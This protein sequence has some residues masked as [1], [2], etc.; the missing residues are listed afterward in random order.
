EETLETF[1]LPLL[2]GRDR[3][4]FLE[5]HLVSAFPRSSYRAAPLIS[6]NLLKPGTAVLT[7]LTTA[8][9]VTSK[10]DKLDIPVTGVWGMSMLL[11]LM[12]RRLDMRDIILVMPS[13]HYLRI[14]VIKEGVPVLTRCIH[15]YHEDNNIENDSDTNEILRTRQH[16]ENHRIFEHGAT[17]PVLYLGDASVI[18]AHLTRAGL[19]LLPVP[20]A[21][22]PDGEA[23]YLHPLFEYVISSPRGQLAPL[24][25]RARHLAENIRLTA[26]LGIAASLLSIVLFGQNDFRALIDLH[27]KDNSLRADLQLAESESQ[28]LEGHISASGLDPALVRQATRFAALEMEAAPTP[29][30]LFRFAASAIADLPQV[31]IKSLTFRFPKAGER[32]CQGHSVIDLPLTDRKID[33]P[34]SGSLPSDAANN[35]AAGV[36]ARHTELQFTILQ[37]E[38]LAPAAQI[39]LLKRIS[40]TLKAR[41]GVQ[42]MEDPAAFSLINTLKGGFGI[43][44]QKTDNLWC[45]SIPWK[46]TQRGDMP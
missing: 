12:A 19:T 31:R 9:A 21:F 26:H 1:K 6:G 42:L 44:T 4:N 45:M 43:D 41:D 40:A 24:Q 20:N 32:Y 5:R 11:T 36:P 27:D 18:T 2:F 10:L 28:R 13:V 22:L 3:S 30:A 7:G 34:L 39:E 38:T 23:G 29:A 17:P 15:R 8:E 25:L 46:I 14:L 33:L 37:N 35:D 16:L